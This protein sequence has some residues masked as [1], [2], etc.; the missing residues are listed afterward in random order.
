[1]IVDYIENISKYGDLVPESVLNFIAKLEGDYTSVFQGSKKKIIDEKNYANFDVYSPKTIDLCRFE[2]HKKYADIQIMLNGE[3]R[4]DIINTDGLSVS[5]E[6][7][8]QKDVMFF[9]PPEKA[10]DKIV[11][12]KGKFVLIYPYEAHCPQIKTTSDNVEKV[13]VKVRLN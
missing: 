12:S 9:K 6:Y 7:D 1:M 4:I 2:A 8:E 10:A 5:D 13:V 11:L 3:E